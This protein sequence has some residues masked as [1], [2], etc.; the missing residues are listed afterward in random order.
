MVFLLFFLILLPSNTNYHKNTN[1]KNSRLPSFI[2]LFSFF[3]FN[4]QNNQSSIFFPAT[5][6]IVENTRK[7]KIHQ[8]RKGNENRKIVF[9]CILLGEQ[10]IY[11]FVRVSKV[12][13]QQ[14]LTVPKRGDGNE[15]RSFIH[16]Q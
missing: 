7:I 3:F 1:E 8:K 12:T 5:T 4:N 16:F 13:S 6:T 9:F 15:M 2:P 14:T 10:K 11:K